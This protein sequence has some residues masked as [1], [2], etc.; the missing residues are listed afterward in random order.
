MGGGCRFRIGTLPLPK[1]CLSHFRVIF[2]ISNRL[3][4][5]MVG[6]PDP[7]LQHYRA[8]VRKYTNYEKEMHSQNQVV[9]QFADS[10]RQRYIN[11]SLLSFS[12]LPLPPPL[13]LYSLPYVPCYFSINI[14]RCKAALRCMGLSFFQLPPDSLRFFGEMRLCIISQISVL[15]YL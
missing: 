1:L 8:I 5:E 2:H 4:R 7:D 14:E 11:L 12:F 10:I 13:A 15:M 9:K 3:V 6:S